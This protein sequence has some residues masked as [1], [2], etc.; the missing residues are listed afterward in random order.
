MHIDNLEARDWLQ[1]RMEN[2]ENRL[3]LTRDQQVRTLTK[4][5]DAVLLEEFVRT[6]YVGMMSFSLEGSETLIPLLDLAIEKRTVRCR[7]PACWASNTV[8]A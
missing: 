1:R 7:R 2:S 5:T 3:R 8:T 4:L 6:K